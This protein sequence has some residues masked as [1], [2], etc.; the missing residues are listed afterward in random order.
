MQEIAGRHINRITFFG[1]Q[2]I[3]IAVF[4]VGRS[5]VIFNRLFLGLGLRCVCRFA[6]D[7][8]TGTTGFRSFRRTGGF[9]RHGTDSTSFCHFRHCTG[10]RHGSHRTGNAFRAKKCANLKDKVPQTL[11]R[12]IQRHLVFIQ[13][14]CVGICAA[15]IRYF[16]YHFRVLFGFFIA[17]DFPPK[18]QCTRRFLRLT[19]GVQHT[20]LDRHFGHA[21]AGITGGFT[22]PFSLFY[23]IPTFWGCQVLA[24]LFGFVY[25][26]ISQLTRH[27][28]KPIP[29]ALFLRGFRDYG[30]IRLMRR[31]CSLWRLSDDFAERVTRPAWAVIAGFD[32]QG[33]IGLGVIVF[34][35]FFFIPFWLGKLTAF[36]F[37][38][39]ILRGLLKFLCSKIGIELI[40]VNVQFWVVSVIPV[41]TRALPV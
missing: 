16:A 29:Y 37:F 27:L 11:P 12:R 40:V 25:G 1:R 10:L 2:S 15:G 9:F 4:F 13:I 39:G 14:E 23:L 24:G 7:F 5:G 35:L 31:I 30:G 20:A 41:K 21:D 3:V 38:N 6:F 17:K 18:I 28:F 34:F 32:R 36:E 8:G 19:A 26:S 33:V 22:N